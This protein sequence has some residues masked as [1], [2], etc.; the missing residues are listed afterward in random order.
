MYSGISKA[1]ASAAVN[2]LGEWL[3]IP[4]ATGN[5]STLCS[6]YGVQNG[7]ETALGVFATFFTRSNVYA[8]MGSLANA[9]GMSAT[10]IVLHHDLA[11]MMQRMWE[12]IDVSEE[13]LALESITAVSPRGNYLEDTLTLKYLRSEEHFYAS[14]FE[15]CAGT[16]DVKTMAERAHGRAQQ[17]INSHTPA[18]PE[19]RLEEVHRYVRKHLPQGW[20][21]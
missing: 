3:D 4:T 19:D 15:Q 2:E 9:C 5:F 20:A 6:N 8:G 21:L 13:K 10:Q 1:L 14:S 16:Q 18:V 12:A 11:R 17:L 7:M